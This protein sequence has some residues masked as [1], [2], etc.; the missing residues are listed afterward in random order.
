MRRILS[1]FFILALTAWAAPLAQAADVSD[2]QKVVDAARTALEQLRADN[3]M[4]PTA[5]DL[6]HKS[7]AVLIVPRLIKAGFFLGGHG[8]SG[9]LVGHNAEPSRVSD[10]QSVDYDQRRR[11]RLEQPQRRNTDRH[12]SNRGA[13]R[14]LRQCAALN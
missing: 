9:V 14:H 8:G 2:E 7:R 11:K 3:T 12:G 1:A 5:R 13:L 6:I 4:G 10:R